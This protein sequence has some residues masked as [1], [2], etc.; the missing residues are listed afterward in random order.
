MWWL[1]IHVSSYIEIDNA[2]AYAISSCSFCSSSF[3]PLKRK[4]I[5]MKSQKHFA[6]TEYQYA[7]SL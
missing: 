5:K 1:N 2:E 7:P 4:T 6:K 3:G